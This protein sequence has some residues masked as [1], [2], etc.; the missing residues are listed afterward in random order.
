MACFDPPEKVLGKDYSIACCHKVWD[1]ANRRKDSKNDLVDDLTSDRGETCFFYPHRPGMSVSA[2]VD[3]ERREVDRREAGRD[4][5]VAKWGH[6]VGALVALTCVLV[7]VGL[8]K[9]LG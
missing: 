4:R 2:A 3:L 1:W 6:V 5:K 9:M 8:T 7:G